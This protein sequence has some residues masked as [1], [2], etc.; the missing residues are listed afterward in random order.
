MAISISPPDPPLSDGVV[1]L[2]P[3]DVDRDAWSVPLIASD[4]ELV[5]WQW[6][7]PVPHADPTEVLRRQLRRWD[8]GTMATF[9][10]DAAGH[11]GRVGAALAILGLAEIF[12]VGE[13]GYLLLPEGRGK[14]YATRAVRLLVGWLFDDLG[15]GRV[16]ARTH[17]DNAASQRVLER[18]GFTSEGVA[19]SAAVFPVTGARFDCGMW[20]L[21]PGELT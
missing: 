18:A 8:E 2:R 16:Q 19:R 9:S 13:V 7:A 5:R 17:L 14:G 20:S 21:L 4:P 1:T 3:P 15:L 6:G 10:I 11:E 12:G